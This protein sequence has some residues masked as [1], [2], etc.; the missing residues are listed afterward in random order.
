MPSPTKRF[1]RKSSLHL[2]QYCTQSFVV[3]VSVSF[4]PVLFPWIHCGCIC[5]N[6]SSMSFSFSILLHS[7]SPSKSIWCSSIHQVSVSHSSNP[8]SS[9]V[10]ITYQ[11][12]ITKWRMDNDDR[13][14]DDTVRPLDRIESANQLTPSPSKAFPSLHSLSSLFTYPVLFLSSLYRYR[15]PH[16]PRYH[17]SWYLRN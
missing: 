1:R 10:P 15:I 5:W 6:E 14:N 8:L 11:S 17:S 4:S 2:S 13:M 12:L 9:F 16:Y 7:S 3:T